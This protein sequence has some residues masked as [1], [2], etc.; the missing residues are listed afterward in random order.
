MLYGEFTKRKRFTE[1]KET[2]ILQNTTYEERSGGI[3]RTDN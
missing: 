3:K 2:V 1:R